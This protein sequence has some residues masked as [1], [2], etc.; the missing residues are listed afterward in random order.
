[1]CNIGYIFCAA[2]NPTPAGYAACTLA[3]I[4]CWDANCKNHPGC[5]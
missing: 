2:K 1:L 4:A 5:C 3:A